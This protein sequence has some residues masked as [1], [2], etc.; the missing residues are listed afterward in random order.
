MRYIVTERE[1]LIIV[2]TLRL[3]QTILLGQ[4]LKYILIIKILHVNI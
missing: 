1:L 4:C 3:F 2:E